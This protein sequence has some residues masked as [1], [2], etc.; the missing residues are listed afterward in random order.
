MNIPS[1]KPPSSPSQERD[2]A[3]ATSRDMHHLTLPRVFPANAMVIAV[4]TFA[5]T[6]MPTLALLEWLAKFTVHG[7]CRTHSTEEENASDFRLFGELTTFRGHRARGLYPRNDATTTTGGGTSCRCRR[8]DELLSWR[9]HT[10]A[11][12]D[13]ALLLLS[14]GDCPVP[15]GGRF[16]VGHSHS[17]V[18]PHMF[19]EYGE[20]SVGSSYIRLHWPDSAVVV[21]P[22]KNLSSETGLPRKR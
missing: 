8:R 17:R 4:R 11:K 15:F 18:P 1:R 7:T 21:V 9:R 16:G 19:L 2:F 14:P 10:L 20:R 13:C 5:R 3:D 22:P 12:L 6:G